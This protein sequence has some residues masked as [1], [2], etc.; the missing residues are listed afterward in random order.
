ML[1]FPFALLTV[2]LSLPLKCF[3]SVKSY[4]PPF[5]YHSLLTSIFMQDLKWNVVKLYGFS[6]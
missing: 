5:T 1:P 3:D 2:L 6:L 4:S